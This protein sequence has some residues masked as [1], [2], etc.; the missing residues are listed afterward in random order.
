MAV[1][2]RQWI[3]NYPDSSNLFASAD[4]KLQRKNIMEELKRYLSGYS[5]FFDVKEEN[6]NIVVYT[7]SMDL[8]IFNKVPLSFDNKKVLVYFAKTLTCEKK[9]FYQHVDLYSEN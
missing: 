6:N 9:D 8:D 7:H 2:E 4:C 1:L 5:W 3:R